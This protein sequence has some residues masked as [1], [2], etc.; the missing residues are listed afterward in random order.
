MASF[1]ASDCIDSVLTRLENNDSFYKRSHILNALNYGL[2]TTNIWLGFAQQE[3]T[4]ISKANKCCY[5]VPYEMVFP[6][7]LAFDGKVLHKSAFSDL[8]NNNQD[9]WKSSTTTK[10]MQPLEWALM[11]TRK[12][13]VYPCDAKG[14]RAL[15]ISGI[16]DAPQFLDETTSI[17]V[18]VNVMNTI[19]DYAAHL[20]QC[21][22]TGRPFFDSLAFYN[23]YRDF[24]KMNSAW[25]TAQQPYY[26][27]EID[28]KQ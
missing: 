20:V 16:V 8:V 19:L 27:Y 18:P 14:G 17:V 28:A 5:D 25:R 7:S 11:G 24:T 9:A 26:K 22:L 4:I 2:Q 21:K 15:Q 13:F 23:G 6:M 12:F 3:I 1:L 10:E